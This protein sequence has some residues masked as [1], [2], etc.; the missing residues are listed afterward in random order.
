M[1]LTK[2]DDK[3]LL[4]STDVNVC[5]LHSSMDVP[6]DYSLFH[7]VSLRDVAPW[8]IVTEMIMKRRFIDHFMYEDQTYLDQFGSVIVRPD[9][10]Y[11]VHMKSV[12]RKRLRCLDD[13]LVKDPNNPK[14][15][16]SKDRYVMMQNSADAARLYLLRDMCESRSLSAYTL[17]DDLWDQ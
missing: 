11:D 10:A 17:I 1:N 9:L 5:G 2:R 13:K 12:I 15:I 4:M 6:L 3:V 7:L 14:L 8:F 16:E